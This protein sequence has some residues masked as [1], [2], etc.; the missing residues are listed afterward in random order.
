[1]DMYGRGFKNNKDFIP[2]LVF[3]VQTDNESVITYSLCGLLTHLGRSLSS[4]HYICEVR[5]IL[6]GGSVMIKE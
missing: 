5:K 2:P 6:Y 4:G 1:M 3:T